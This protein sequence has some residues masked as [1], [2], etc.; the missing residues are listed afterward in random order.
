[1]LLSVVQKR[2][3]VGLLEGMGEL[4][5]KWTGLGATE[6][7]WEGSGRC[8]ISVPPNWAQL[9]VWYIIIQ[10]LLPVVDVSWSRDSMH[11]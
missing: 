10:C 9:G 11:D 3:L 4:E 8:L 6:V 1:M 2:M 5:G 7:V